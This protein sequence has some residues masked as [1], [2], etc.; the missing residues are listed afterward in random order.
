MRRPTF[1]LIG[2]VVAVLLVAPGPLARTAGGDSLK[3][4]LDALRGAR[5]LDSRHPAKDPRGQFIVYAAKEKMAKKVLNVAVQN[6]ARA[7]SFFG[8]SIIW[9]QPAVLIV[10]PD[11]KTY[12][13]EWELFGT[14]GVQLQFRYKGRKI[15]LIITYE[16]DK[17]LERTLP[18]ELMHLLI[19]D[20]SN[21][22]YFDGRRRDLVPTPVW[23]QEGLAEYMT[24]DPKRRENFEKFLYW[25]LYRKEQ[26]SLERLLE[27]MDYDDKIMLHYAESYSF[28]AFIAA[29]VPNGRLRLRNYITSYN[30]KELAEDPLRAFELAFQ[31]VAPSI[32]VLEKRWHA[33]VGA[34]YR[35][36]FSP[37]VLRTHPADKCE[38]AAADGRIWV[39][40]D[41]PIDPATVGSKTI[42]LHKAGSKKLGDN[43]QNLLRKA[44]FLLDPTGC[45]LFIEL[46]GGIEAKSRYTLAFSDQVTDKHRHGLVAKKFGEMKRFGWWEDPE[47]ESAPGQDK[48]EQ[49]KKKRPR[50]VLTVKFTTKAKD[51][52]NAPVDR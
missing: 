31:G 5:Y 47:K 11:E 49:K 7:Q 6:R 12:L 13:K 23:I 20:M 43:E 51:G 41:K 40:F 9:K 33:W 14:G 50:L 22:H 28:I 25:S 21:R 3:P 2:V 10:Y 18:H 1:L 16:E 29:T 39:K 34:R 44:S 15:K 36:H 48:T 30:K 32:D 37:I 26:I 27:Q 35:G 45:V 8:T 19:T 38:D 4:F 24:A 52:G 46:P 42:A 17:L